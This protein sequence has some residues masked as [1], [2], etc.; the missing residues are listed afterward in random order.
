MDLIQLLEKL[1]PPNQPLAGRFLLFRCRQCGR[2]FR[3]DA[4][5]LRLPSRLVAR[6]PKCGGHEVE[7]EGLLGDLDLMSVMAPLEAACHAASAKLKGLNL[8]PMKRVLRHILNQLFLE[9][10]L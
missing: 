8:D 9:M 10:F 2:K 1:L 3:R 4:R 6:C 7:M 5:L